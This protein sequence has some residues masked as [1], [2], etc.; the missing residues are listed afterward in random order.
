MSLLAKPIMMHFSVAK[1]WGRVFEGCY[2]IY[3]KEGFSRKKEAILRKSGENLK[4]AGMVQCCRCGWMLLPGLWKQCFIWNIIPDD[5]YKHC[6]K[7]KIIVN[8]SRRYQENGMFQ[9]YYCPTRQLVL[10]Y[11]VL[12]VQ[13]LQGDSCCWETIY[14]EINNP[15]EPNTKVLLVC[16]SG[17]L[18]IL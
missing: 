13:I 11:L 4:G 9:K 8:V 2:S 5:T 10:E 15:L 3:K 17:H 16:S 18:D 14:H 6:R 7:W 12:F 1:T